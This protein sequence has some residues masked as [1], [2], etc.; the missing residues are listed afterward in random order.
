M[1]LNIDFIDAY[2]GSWMQKKQLD[3]IV[4]FNNK[5]FQR[6]PGIELFDIK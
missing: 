6:I 2:I 3:K 4:T 1:T 5:D